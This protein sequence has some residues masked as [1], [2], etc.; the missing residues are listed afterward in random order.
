MTDVGH[1]ELR[2][3]P[4]TRSVTFSIDGRDVTVRAT[5]GGTAVELVMTL[6]NLQATL[7]GLQAGIAASTKGSAGKG[8]A[9]KGSAR[10]GRGKR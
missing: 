1:N 7:D 6:A 3:V 8:S 10:K 5:E 9:G 2:V 4:A